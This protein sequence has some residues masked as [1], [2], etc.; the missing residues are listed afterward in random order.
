M[1]CTLYKQS[2]VV[3]DEKFL[4]MVRAAVMAQAQAVLADTAHADYEQ[5]AGLSR[6]LLY[7]M[8]APVTIDAVMRSFAWAVVNTSSL[9]DALHAAGGD[10]TLVPDDVIAEA[11]A[12]SWDTAAGVVPQTAETA[13][14]MDAEVP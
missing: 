11:V 4:D 9:M 2:Q 7:A 1:V 10:V 3:A 5:R 8:S 13:P 14:P 6:T 12:A